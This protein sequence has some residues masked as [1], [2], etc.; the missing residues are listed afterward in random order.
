MK[1]KITS[2][3]L[4]ALMCLM[5]VD[6]YALEKNGEGVYQIGTA[7]DLL[8]FAELVNT[9]PTCSALMT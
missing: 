7:Q 2:F 4:L 9:E 8:D 1:Q 3:L 6:A 5:G